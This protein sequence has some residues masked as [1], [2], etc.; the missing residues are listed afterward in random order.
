MGRIVAAQV[1]GRTGNDAL[2]GLSHGVHR[3]VRSHGTSRKQQLDLVTHASSNN[4]AQQL[5]IANNLG[6]WR[7][8]GR[9]V[10]HAVE[11]VSLVQVLHQLFPRRIGRRPVAARLVGRHDLHMVTGKRLGTEVVIDIRGIANNQH[12]HRA[13][14]L[15]KFAFCQS[16]TCV[17]ICAFP[18]VVNVGQRGNYKAVFRGFGSLCGRGHATLSRFHW[19][20]RKSTLYHADTY[21]DTY[22]VARG[23]LRGRPF[24]AAD[25]RKTPEPFYQF[26]RKEF[27]RGGRI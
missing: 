22:A 1:V 4:G 24:S 9:K 13:L 20:S 15:L 11:F 12:F 2:A 3:T 25:K 8:I 6:I 17:S 27:G 21:T 10:D 18:Y 16:L 26:R 14:P 7:E 5:D 23:Y 19:V